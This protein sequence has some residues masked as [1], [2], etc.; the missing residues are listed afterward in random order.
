M[1]YKSPDPSK[2]RRLSEIKSFENRQ[3]EVVKSIDSDKKVQKKMEYKL[4]VQIRKERELGDEQHEV[5]CKR[6]KNHGDDEDNIRKDLA[7]AQKKLEQLSK[8]EESANAALAP[9]RDEKEKL[10]E[11]LVLK[12]VEVEK[13]KDAVFL[14]C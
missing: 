3:R 11:E 13:I 10:E 14:D 12:R 8:K 2:K 1:S 7:A 5:N 6:S 4:K 9:V